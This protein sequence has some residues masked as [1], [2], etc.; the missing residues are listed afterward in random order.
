MRNEREPIIEMN[1]KN[2]R[3]TNTENETPN[4][5]SGV[6]ISAEAQNKIVRLLRT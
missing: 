1:T 4:K 2:T 6:T 5:N 3:K